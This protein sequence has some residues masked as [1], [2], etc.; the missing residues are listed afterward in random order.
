MSDTTSP[1][2]EALIAAFRRYGCIREDIDAMPSIT[3]CTWHRLSIGAEVRYYEED[4]MQD[5]LDELVFSG[6]VLQCRQSRTH[7]P[8]SHPYP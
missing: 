1:A 6:A 3:F 8:E 7:N 5:L 2:A 4:D